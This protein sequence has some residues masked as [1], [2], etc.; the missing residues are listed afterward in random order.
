MT[1]TVSTMAP[2]SVT[3]PTSSVTLAPNQNQVVTVKFSPT[4]VGNYSKNIT[5]AT[6]SSSVG[7]SVTGTRFDPQ[8][9]LPYLNDITQR[10]V[11]SETQL[12]AFQKTIETSNMLTKIGYD[13]TLFA[14]DMARDV[15]IAFAGFEDLGSG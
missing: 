5:L 11:G 8:V 2:F 13:G 7:L 14:R 1:L 12:D 9:N 4:A 10:P 6:T 15:N 3:S